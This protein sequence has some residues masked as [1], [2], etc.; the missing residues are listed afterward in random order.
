MMKK[1]ITLFAIHALASACYADEI[2]CPLDTIIKTTKTVI[3]TDTITGQTTTTITETEKTISTVNEPQ[4]SIQYNGS[5][6]NMIFSWRKKKR[7]NPHWTGFGMGFMNYSDKK[8]PYGKLKMSTSHNFTVNLFDFHRQI[9]KT[10]WLFVSGIGAEWSRYHFDENAAI[11]KKDGITFFEPAPEGIN[12]KSTK[13]LA[14]Y[15]TI[16]LLL[17]YQISNFHISGGAVGFI[18][19]YSKSQVKYYIDDNKH[20]KNM[21]RDLNIRPIDMKLRF[22]VG[23]DDISIYAYYSPFSMFEKDKGPK[24]KT[25]TIGIMLGI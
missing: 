25:Y 23:I 16:P 24:L 21:G 22:Q 14:Y 10:N 12:Y 20:V 19:Y 15:I 17:E 8:I 3:I 1:I 18:K 7:L 5:S 13:L 6:Y 4:S 11:T 2:K 9:G